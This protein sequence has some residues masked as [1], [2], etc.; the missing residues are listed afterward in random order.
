MK[1]TP[2]AEFKGHLPRFLE[3]ARKEPVFVT[4]NGKITAVVEAISDDEVEDY[5]LERS[6]RFRT[7]LR[8]VAEKTGGMSLKTYRRERRR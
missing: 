3:L 8:R 2:I 4:R 6:P 5:M 1:V 7:M